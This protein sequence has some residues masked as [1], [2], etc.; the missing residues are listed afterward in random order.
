MDEQGWIKDKD[1]VEVQ[2]SHCAQAHLNAVI[3]QKGLHRKKLHY[4][5]LI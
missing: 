4:L 1:E 5:Y 3:C 2:D